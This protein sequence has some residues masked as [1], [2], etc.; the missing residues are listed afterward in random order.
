M[1]RENSTLVSYLYGFLSFVKSIFL[2]EDAQI[3]K[4]VKD[5]DQTQKQCKDVLKKISSNIKKV[6]NDPTK[7]RLSLFC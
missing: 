1:Y 2:F 3:D 6:S 7:V 4:T 5:L